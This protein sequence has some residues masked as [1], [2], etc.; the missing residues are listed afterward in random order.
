MATMTVGRALEPAVVQQ[1]PADLVWAVEELATVRLKLEADLDQLRAEV[2]SSRGQLADP[3]NPLRV[4]GADDSMAFASHA[5][6]LEHQLST[7]DNTSAVL[8]QTE[9]ALERLIGGEYVS[10]EACSRAVGKARQQSLPRAV[11]C[12]RCQ[13]R[14][15]RRIA[16]RR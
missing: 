7:L 13:Q 10:C 3:M 14:R 16:V 1:V 11:T 6:E 4:G 12:L 8:A 2:G 9:R 5:T 15:D